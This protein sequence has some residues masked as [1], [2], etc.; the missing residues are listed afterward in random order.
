MNPH[1]DSTRKLAGPGKGGVFTV[2]LA[3][4]S[5]LLVALLIQRLFLTGLTERAERD[6]ARTLERMANEFSPLLPA[7]PALPQTVLKAAEQLG[8][9]LTVLSADGRVLADSAVDPARLSTVENHASR[10]EIVAAR[11]SGIGFDRR[12]SATVAEP[13]L[14]A[15]RR[16]DHSG[17]P[18][19][20]LRIAVTESEL[21]FPASPFN[22][23]VT[24]LSS[25]AG[26]L[27]GVLVLALRRRHS[28]ELVLVK[29][30]ARRALAGETSHP[31]FQT[32]EEAAEV[33]AVLGDAAKLINAR[34]ED[35]RE[36]REM[37]RALLTLVPEG[38][39][40][41]DQNLKFMDANP[42]FLELLG[43]DPA[44]KTAGR[45]FIEMSRHQKLV[46]VLERAIAGTAVSEEIDVEGKNGMRRI[47][48]VALPVSRPPRQAAAV[49]LRPVKSA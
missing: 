5:G 8:W 17:A 36:A 7:D 44:T 39:A 3:L 27:A 21:L 15:A 43:V 29:D 24:A 23:K 14:Y 42:A 18:A 11:D 45:H 33:Y 1:G 46:S 30:A 35:A 32:S 37:V 25:F 49:L 28:G 26:L 20:Y 48:A 13:F 31:A 34:T 16:I 10:P 12:R 19:G 41:F 47:E 22:R 6:L 40:L 4:L 9:R 38:L 2:L